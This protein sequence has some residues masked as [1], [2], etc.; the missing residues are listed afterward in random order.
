MQGTGECSVERL[1]L[2]CV[3]VYIYILVMGV[4]SVTFS[5]VVFEERTD[6]QCSVIWLLLY[7]VTLYI[8]VL[9]VEDF[10]VRNAVFMEGT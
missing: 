8:L 7:C 5:N 9:V 2:Y 1:V 4:E 10:I 3:T 6:R